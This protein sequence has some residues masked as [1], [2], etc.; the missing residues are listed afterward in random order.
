SSEKFYSANIQADVTPQVYARIYDVP[1][2]D[3][4]V[5]QYW[6]Y[7]YNNSWGHR[8]GFQRWLGL[9]EGDWEM[10][11]V[12]LTG[13]FQPEYVAYAQHTD[14]FSFLGIK[15]GSKRRWGTVKLDRETNKHPIVYVALGSH[16]SYFSSGR[17][18]LNKDETAPE[19]EN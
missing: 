17:F 1:G 2:N 8:G 16:A 12:V 7:Y 18:M 14:I 19:S 10:V 3:Y 15:G 6:L 11:Q 5:I 4:R 9:H 13:K